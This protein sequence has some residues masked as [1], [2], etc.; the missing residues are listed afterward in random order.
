MDAPCRADFV[1]AIITAEQQVVHST[2]EA[3][4]NVSWPPNTID[5][6]TRFNR[7]GHEPLRLYETWL[8][9]TATT[10]NARI[11]NRISDVEH[12]RPPSSC[13]RHQIFRSLP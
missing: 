10:Q 9:T 2:R 7:D 13:R 3:D 11:A 8:A 6:P 4:K 1:G 12:Y 5:L